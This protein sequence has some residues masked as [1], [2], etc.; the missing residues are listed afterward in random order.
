ILDD[1]YDEIVLEVRS[2]DHSNYNL[3]ISNS[4][5][6]IYQK[7]ENVSDASEISNF[8]GNSYNLILFILSKI[9]RVNLPLPL[10]KK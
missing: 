2:R 4:K 6:I 3:D 5:D 8:I 10:L 9:S 1:K 7:I